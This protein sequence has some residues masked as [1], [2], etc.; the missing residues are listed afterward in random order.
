MLYE[1]FFSIATEEQ[2]AAA[3]AMVSDKGDGDNG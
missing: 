3:V 2:R 1:A